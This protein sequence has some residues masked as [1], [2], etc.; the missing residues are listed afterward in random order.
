MLSNLRQQLILTCIAIVALAMLAVGAVNF[1]TVRS[2]TL[3]SI[4]SQALQL[5]Q[6]HA[7]GITEWVRSKQAAVASLKPAAA[8]ADPLS[9]IKAAEKA[10]D[11]DLSYIG[12]ANKQVIFS[13]IRNWPSDYD[14]TIR[15]WYLQAVKVG[16]PTITTPYPDAATGN[17]VVTFAEP[18]GEK[19]HVSAVAAADVVLTVVV[20]NVNSIKPTPSSYAFLIDGGG[21]IIAHPDPSLTMKPV[22]TLDPGLNVPRLQALSGSGQGSPIVLDG[23]DMMLYATKVEG[24]DWMLTTVLDNKEATQSLSSMIGTSAVT[25]VLVLML[26]AAALTVL[27]RR[28]LIDWK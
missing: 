27:V 7:A 11:F 26:A 21:N 8:T 16:G 2:R 5:S 17:L 10:G 22:L 12:F 6:S 13:Q 3:D 1:F 20:A 25:A 14:P 19:D 24:T 9:V 15:P 18:I 23:R 28:V 4:N